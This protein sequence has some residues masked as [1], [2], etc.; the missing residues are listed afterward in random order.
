MTTRAHDDSAPTS[1]APESDASGSEPQLLEHEYDGIREYDNPLPGWWVRLFWLSFVFSL[2]YLFHYHLSDNGTSVARAYDE[3]MAAAREERAKALLTEAVSESALEQVMNDP[4][5]IADAKSLFTQ[6]CAM[7]HADKGQGLIGPNLTDGYWIHDNGT[8]MDIYKAV[9]DGFPDKG[10]PAWGMQLTP[11][12]Q[13]KL[14]AFV[15]SLRGQ[16][17]PGKA[18]EGTPVA[19]TR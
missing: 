10:M 7:C 1:H 11:F 19:Q 4:A 8:L 15:G 9:R 3:E 16:D 13:R 6:R 18:A 5:L 12:E 2:G 17:L 14:A